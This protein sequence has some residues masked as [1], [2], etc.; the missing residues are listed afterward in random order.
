MDAGV[1]CA[2][3]DLVCDEAGALATT[4]GVAAG[5]IGQRDGVRQR[6]GWF[7]PRVAVADARY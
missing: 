5:A 3:D 4:R 1:A 7:S 6:R 2:A